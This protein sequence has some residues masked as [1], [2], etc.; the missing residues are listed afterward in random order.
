MTDLLDEL[1]KELEELQTVRDELKVQLHLAKADAKDEW[2]RLQPR[3]LEAQDKLKQLGAQ[4]REP[5][6]DLKVA[7]R[8][9]VGEIKS[10]LQ[11]IRDSF[12]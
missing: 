12:Q 11:R 5:A 2:E 4:T 3:L 1:K 7:T 6:E 8:E 9:L 10:G